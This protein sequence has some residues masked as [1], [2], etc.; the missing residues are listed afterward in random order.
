MNWLHRLSIEGLPQLAGK[1]NVKNRHCLIQM[2]Q[3]LDS[4]VDIITKEKQAKN[5]TVDGA[6]TDTVITGDNTGIGTTTTMKPSTT[7]DVMAN[8]KGRKLP[9]SDKWCS[10]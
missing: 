9:R 5:A 10:Y 6:S 8:Y 2:I 3:N 4:N 7:A 1:T